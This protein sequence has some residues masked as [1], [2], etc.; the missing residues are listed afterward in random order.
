MKVLCYGVRDVEVPIFESCNKEFNYDLKLV[1]DYLNSKETAEMAK[2]F[3]A[4]ILR[5]NCF[6]NKE[7][8][9]IYKEVGV[10]YVLTRTAGTDHIDVEYAKKLGFPMAFVPRYS[11]NAIA[12]LAVTQAMMLLRHTAYMTSRTARK[13]FEVDRV[14][15]SKEVRNCTVGV[16]GLGRIGRVAA[17]L[18]HGLGATVIGSDVFQIK[19]LGDYCTQVPVEEVLAKSDIVTIHAP[20]IKENGPVVTKDFLSQMKDGAILIN[21]ARGQLADTAAVIEAV[22]SGKLGGYGC[23]VIDGEDEIFGQDL[24]GKTL[25][26]PLFEKLVALYPKVLITPHMGSYTD[27]AAKNM[28]EISFQSLKELSEGLECPN[29]IK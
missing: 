11:P 16:V 26:N 18:F 9:D 14:M 5:G 12:E 28:V 6:A 4:V 29:R 1:P 22:E 19:G 20:Y 27:E 25:P 8:L 10:K 7:A 24:E 13:N 3:D 15:F 17:Q 2:G 23:D 21:C